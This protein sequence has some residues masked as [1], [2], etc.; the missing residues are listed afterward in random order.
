MPHLVLTL[1][2]WALRV[3]VQPSQSF[4]SHRGS[5]YYPP[6][7]PYSA[8]RRA[9]HS[10]IPSPIPQ[11]PCCW[12]QNPQDPVGCLLSQLSL[13]SLPPPSQHSFPISCRSQFR[14][15]P[16][17]KRH[18]FTRPPCHSPGF[19]CSKLPPALGSLSLCVPHVCMCVRLLPGQCHPA[20]SQIM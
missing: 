9:Q 19:S 20:D 17:S 6:L 8:L 11:A 14:S 5:P 7:P 1:V 16:L 12:L 10:L 3:H 4:Q 18:V 15:C 2:L 13:P